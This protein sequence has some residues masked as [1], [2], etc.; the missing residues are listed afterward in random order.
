MKERK[1]YTYFYK[2]APNIECYRYR[3]AVRNILTGKYYSTAE[4][5]T[6]DGNEAVGERAIEFLVENNIE[7]D[8]HQKGYC[9]GQSTV[10]DNNILRRED[11]LLIGG[12]SESI[13]IAVAEKQREEQREG[14]EDKADG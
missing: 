2:V 6:E 8:I 4:S 9:H 1:D 7:K 12:A 3:A 11:R 5:Y 14:S 10:K 13:E